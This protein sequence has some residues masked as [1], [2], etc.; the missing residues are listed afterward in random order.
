MQCTAEFNTLKYVYIWLG[1]YGRG[2]FMVSN[3]RMYGN[4]FTLCEGAYLYHLVKKRTGL[5]SLIKQRNKF[6]MALQKA[7]L[8]TSQKLHWFISGGLTH[9]SEH[10]QDFKTKHVED[11][12]WSSTPELRVK[13]WDPSS[14]TPMLNAYA[15]M[16]WPRTTI[17]RDWDLCVWHRNLSSYLETAQCWPS[18][19]NLLLLSIYSLWVRFAIKDSIYWSWCI[20]S[21]CCSQMIIFHYFHQGSINQNDKG[22]HK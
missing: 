2:V 22:E 12:P 19:N 13:V 8:R 1:P 10:K 17:T 7:E 16:S 4:G 6:T 18:R 9:C 11:Q 3:N 5:H 20:M 15:L 21:S 14:E